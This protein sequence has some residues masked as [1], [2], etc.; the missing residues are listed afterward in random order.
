M[1]EDLLQFNNKWVKLTDI[2]GNEFIGYASYD[3]SEEESIVIRNK[4]NTYSLISFFKN[5]IKNIIVVEKNG[6]R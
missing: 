6:E 4:K 2:D 1:I 3:D 5:E